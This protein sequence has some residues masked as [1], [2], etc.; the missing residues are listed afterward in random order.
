MK[1]IRL[2]CSIAF[3]FICGNLKANNILLSNIT[4]VSGSGFVQIQFDLSW[5]N[6]WNN[7][8]NR[9]AAWV[10]FKFK[11][12]DGT[13]RHLNLTGA[14]TFIASGYSIQVPTDLTGAFIYRNSG[15]GTITLTGV[16]LGVTILPGSFDVKGFALEMVRIPVEATYRDNIQYAS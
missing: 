9:D 13:W 1:S 14:N 12:N 3:I 11:D 2:L 16:Q 6:S 7:A 4:S 15:S 10:F 8:I 5:D